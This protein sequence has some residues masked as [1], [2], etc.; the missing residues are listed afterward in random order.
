MRL[1]DLF[2][3]VGGFSLSAEWVWGDELEILGFVETDKFCQKVLKKHWPNVPIYGD[4]RNLDGKEFRPVDLITGGFPCQPFSVAGKRGGRA[5]DRY[6][7]PEM[8]RV[9][10][11]AKP[12]WVIGE[13]V[14][15]IVGMA[16]DTVLFDLESINYETQTFI[17][18]ACGV[19][20]PHRR[21][22]VWIIAHDRSTESGRLSG[23]RG[24]EMAQIGGGSQDVAYSDKQG[25]SSFGDKKGLRKTT[26]KR[27][28]TGIERRSCLQNTKSDWWAIEPA[29]GELVNGVSN[30][31]V[32]F[33]G[34]V[35]TGVKNRVNKLKVL[36]NSIVPQVVMPIMQAIKEINIY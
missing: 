30:R 2:S 12:T 32:R 33:E 7:W 26:D 34:R 11:E 10:K 21:Y 23:I 25:F 9:I 28:S 17:I 35:A 14:T 5:D 24:E 1:F 15:G 6:L 29:M 16:L 13:N 27:P 18:P 3:G 4:I 8:F 36:G 31:L 19:N 20:A 22:R